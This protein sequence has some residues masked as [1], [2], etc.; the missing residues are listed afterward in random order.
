MNQIIFNLTEN[1]TKNECY[2][3]K[4]RLVSDSFEYYF[5]FGFNFKNWFRS[6]THSKF[7]EK[8]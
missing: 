3:K 7:C 2:L 1:I 6:L 5:R 4:I 8:K